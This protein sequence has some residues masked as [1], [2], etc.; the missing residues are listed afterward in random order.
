MRIAE[1]SLRPCLIE[2]L[3][4]SAKDELEVINKVEK[5]IAQAKYLKRRKKQLKATLDKNDLAIR[6]Q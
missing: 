5:K 1:L 4:V 2:S 6:S 3:P